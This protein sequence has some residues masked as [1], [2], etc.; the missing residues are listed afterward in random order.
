MT[1]Q[2]DPHGGAYTSTEDRIETL[3]NALTTLQDALDSLIPLSGYDRETIANY[4]GK[5]DRSMQN[6]LS[7][8][9]S[10]LEDTV[11]NAQEGIE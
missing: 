10:S 2:Q 4:I 5:D 7:D 11:E 1:K 6:I 8:L 9:I 3:E